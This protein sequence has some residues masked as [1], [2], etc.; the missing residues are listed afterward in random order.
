[1]DYI[2]TCEKFDSL[3]AEWDMLQEES[4]G[5]IIFSSPQW[6][7]TWWKHFGADYTLYLGSLRDGAK[8]IG[9][10]PLAVSDETATFS[11]G[12]DVCDYLDF[13]VL[14][15]YED[16]F[17]TIL[18]DRL[19]SDGIKRLDL[20]AVRPDSI[21]FTCLAQQI[22]QRGL[23]LA[24]HQEDVTVYMELPSSW[25]H[26]LKELSGKQRHELKRKFRRLEEMGT[27][28]QSAVTKASPDTIKTFFR[29]F[30]ECREDKAQ[31]LT[32]DRKDFMQDLIEVM[33]KAG[34]LRFNLMEL[35]GSSVAI[36]LC[37]DYKKEVLLYN[38]GFD[39]EYRWL[40][41]GLISKA[42]VI[43]N[44]IARNMSCFN[45]LKGDEQ[46]KYRLG[47]RSMPLYRCT[48]ELE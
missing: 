28:R 22:K 15:G 36:T 30:S 3:A 41:A 34:R 17:C 9:V 1:M 35:N 29:L 25:E 27:V 48:V 46:Y 4:P 37:F 33:A 21:V 24:Y 10:A 7:G 14:P 13:T 31:F 40:S 44:S 47:G 5:S 6:T 16:T 42:M 2:F 18:L 8:L 11:G 32:P 19:I 43:E 38:S 39:P 45:F 23:S 12:P 20:G 26:Y